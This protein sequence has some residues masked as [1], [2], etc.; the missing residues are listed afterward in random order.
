MCHV[1]KASAPYKDAHDRL[2]TPTPQPN[3]SLTLLLAAMTIEIAG[4]TDNF[5]DPMAN[6]VLSRQRVEARRVPIKAGVAASSKC[7]Y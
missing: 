2:D 1:R 7:R 6:V 5:F 3:Q 4:S